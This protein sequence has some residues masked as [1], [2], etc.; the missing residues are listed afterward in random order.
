MAVSKT[1][2]KFYLTG[3]EYGVEQTDPSQSLGPYP[4]TTEVNPSVLLSS[5]MSLTTNELTLSGPLDAQYALIGDELM[6]LNG[7]AILSRA[8]AMT[9]A[10]FH[11]TGDVVYGV[12]K[13]NLFN[14]SFSDTNKQYRCIAVTNT[15]ET[16][17]F[18]NLRFYFKK[19]SITS[20]ST[21]R[22]A[23]EQP[24]IDVVRSVADAG[25]TISIIDSSL[26]TYATD[27]FADCVL[28]I[29]DST[30]ENVNLSRKIASFDQESGTITFTTAFPS[31]ITAGTTFRIE[32][33]P[34]QSVASGILTP[35]FGTTYV[36]A[37]TAADG[38]A[39]A[40]GI[41]VTGFRSNGENL[42]PKE[43]VYLWFE[44]TATPDATSIEN[45]RVIFTA[46]YKKV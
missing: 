20:A 26:T 35:A 39:N 38:P 14:S 1:D 40:I 24:R 42:G 22:M 28:T 33:S 3:L 21:V 10:R 32:N 27:Y 13:P 8:A 25:S 9:N 23:V 29:D 36:T 34:S 5:N 18:F 6:T 17:T 15:N 4:S 31:P 37:L 46:I 2:L 44:R 43:T 11:S 7:T 45:N 19:S 30:S 41:N 16:E 12:T